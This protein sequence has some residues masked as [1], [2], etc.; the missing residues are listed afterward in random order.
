MK[1]ACARGIVLMVAFSGL[2]FGADWSPRLAADYLDG[3]EKAWFEWRNAIQYAGG[4]CISC[5]TGIPY[6][7]ARPRLRQTLHETQPTSWEQ[8][9]IGG[10]RARVDITDPAQFSKNPGFINNPRAARFVS[11]ESIFAALLLTLDNPASPEVPRA[12]DRMW[13]MQLKDGAD[14]GAWQWLVTF[15]DPSSNP[16]ATYFG[17]S[18]A[19][20]AVASAPAEYRKRADVQ[21][22]VASLAA[23]FESH[24]ENQPLYNRLSLLWASSKLPSI[25]PA[26]AQRSLIDQ[27]L[28]KQ[29]ADGGWKMESLGPWAA[30]PEA[31]PSSG[32]SSYATGY[33]AL[34]LQK[35][36]MKPSN[37]AL[38]RALTWLRTHQDPQAGY[39]EAQSM[40][41]TFD[42]GS[43]MVQFARDTATAYAA[44]ALLE[45]GDAGK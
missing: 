8:G 24:L 22:H 21:G 17:A 38:A 42:A 7:M 27:T 28:K 31:P 35:A 37:P 19:A 1:P 12:F 33:V 41:K 40:N 3:R 14:Q 29:E 18:L 26:A 4:P 9:L 16:E 13:S 5:H 20:M 30:H 2:G 10:V 44:L 15:G 43:M 11:A 25:L 32:S 6:L 23:Y 45:A 34:T 36:G 39:W